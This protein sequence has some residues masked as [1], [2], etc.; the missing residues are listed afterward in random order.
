MSQAHALEQRLEFMKLDASARKRI[1]SVEPQIREALPGALGAFY[2]QLKG[3][4]ETARFFSSQSHI[5]KRSHR[6]LGRASFSKDLPP[7]TAGREI[8]RTFFARRFP[9]PM[10]A[11]CGGRN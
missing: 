11:A 2:S 4:P 5:D 8:A 3:N 9:S 10:T 6:R 7:C 1:K